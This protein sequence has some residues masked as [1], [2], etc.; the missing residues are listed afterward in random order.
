[1]PQTTYFKS[2][3]FEKKEFGVDFMNTNSVIKLSCVLDYTR[4][5]SQ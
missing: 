5:I 2:N 4:L 1:M 3:T